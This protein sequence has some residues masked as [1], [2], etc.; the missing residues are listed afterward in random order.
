M[1]QSTEI[2]FSDDYKTATFLIDSAAA[3]KI[4]SDYK[5]NVSLLDGE[6]H[7]V[8][9]VIADKKNV[10]LKKG[11]EQPNIT[12]TSDQDTL[13]VDFKVK[14]DDEALDLSHY[15]IY[16][17][18]D[19][20]LGTLDEYLAEDY[21]EDDKAKWVDATE[22]KA[23][24]FELK[25]AADLTVTPLQA[26]KTYKVVVDTEE[27]R[28]DKGD[29]LSESQ[30]TIKVKMPSLSEAQ[31]TAKLA[32]IE[33]TDDLKTIVVSFDKDINSADHTFNPAL[34][35]I[36]TAGGKVVPGGKV[37]DNQTELA[38]NELRLEVNEAL[39][40]NQTYK[41]YL[42]TNGVTNAYFSNAMNKEVKGLEAKAQKNIEVKSMKA[43]FLLDTDKE[44]AD[45]LLEFDQR[46]KLESFESEGT[47]EIKEKG[48]TFKLT[49]GAE[50]EYYNEDKTGKTVRIKDVEAVFT[51]LEL[52][53]GKTYEVSIPVGKVKTD[54]AKN[55]QTNTS[56]LVSTISGAN[57]KAPKVDGVEF[58]SEKEVVVTFDQEINSSSIKPEDVYI[59]GYELLSNGEISGDDS[60]ELNGEQ[61]KISVSGDKLT[62][63]PA[64]DRIKLATGM[65]L[66]Y[67]NTETEIGN[68]KQ[69]FIT[70]SADAV[71]GTNGIVATKKL[72]LSDLKVKDIKDNAAP[73]ILAVTATGAN[74]ADVTYS[75]A[76]KFEDEA[77]SATTAKQFDVRG[78]QRNAY[79]T[80]ANITENKLTITFN[81]PNTFKSSVSYKDAELIYSPKADYNVQDTNKRNAAKVTHKGIV[82]KVN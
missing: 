40:T 67:A 6:N 13:V 47:I 42:P 56:K 48:K 14:M 69:E 10:I 3:E 36:K 4:K 23:I 64:N 76:V 41:V 55:P 50:V 43:S 18:S 35:E 17:E 74:T 82:N 81:E 9:T 66:N 46:V 70:I 61:L 24:K 78:V 33:S 57:V 45:L 11:L 29:K 77:S 54:A 65:G 71:K 60:Q 16:D 39:D 8:A 30:K 37:A 21:T 62:I 20:E 68:D 22:K 51:G 80:E 52:E 75:E 53:N 79:G 63:K 44:T 2:T 12:V 7:E 15:T 73:I 31:P 49:S 38:D 32:R 19:N 25:P 27:V 72:D 58:K 1:A 59:Q 26:G 28:T 34:V 5:Y